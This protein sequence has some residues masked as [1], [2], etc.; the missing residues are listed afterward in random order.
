MKPALPSPQAAIVDADG[1]PTPE[2]YRYLQALI[3]PLQ[4]WSTATGTATRTT[5]DTG[6]VT[7]EQLAER[8]KG[9]LDDMRERGQI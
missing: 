6:T 5:F 3:T 8:V 7:T 4:D 9:L 2:F 1:R